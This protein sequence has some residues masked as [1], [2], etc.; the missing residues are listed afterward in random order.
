LVQGG[1]INEAETCAGLGRALH[2]R[3]HRCRIV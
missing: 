3:L 1:V 2:Q